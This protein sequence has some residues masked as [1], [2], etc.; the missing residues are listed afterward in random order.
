[1]RL[2]ANVSSTNTAP[3][4]FVCIQS[5]TPPTQR[6]L[7]KIVFQFPDTFQACFCA[8]LTCLGTVFLNKQHQT[9]HCLP[10]HALKRLTTD[11][12]SSRVNVHARSVD[13]D[14]KERRRCAWKWL[15][16]RHFQHRSSSR[17]YSDVDWDITHVNMR[18]SCGKHHRPTG[19]GALP[20]CCRRWLSLV[21]VWRGYCS[22]S[23][24]VLDDVVVLIS[25][26]IFKCT[27]S[28]YSIE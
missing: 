11:T 9:Y 23:E 2:P 1:M 21:L 12:D 27:S 18:L 10:L 16:W 19:Y 26:N 13:R 24:T 22:K 20:I 28:L 6:L 5:P 4:T 8:L 17:C 14:A 15:C 25:Y 7:D 3:L